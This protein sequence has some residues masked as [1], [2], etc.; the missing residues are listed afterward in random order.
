MR[1]A[2]ISVTLYCQGPHIAITNGGTNQIPEIVLNTLAEG[3][4]HAVPGGMLRKCMSQGTPTTHTCMLVFVWF[5]DSH[6]PSWSSRFPHPPFC[7]KMTM[8]ATPY[9]NCAAIIKER[10]AKDL[11]LRPL[12]AYNLSVRSLF[13]STRPKFRRRSPHC[14]KQLAEQCHQHEVGVLGECCH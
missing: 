3:R 7:L 6:L 8:Y 14:E 5:Q 11:L 13:I 2:M 9:A 4:Y 10:M 12:T 1:N